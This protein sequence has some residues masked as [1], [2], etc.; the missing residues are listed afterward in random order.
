LG[1]L[2]NRVWDLPAPPDVSVRS[3]SSAVPEIDM[4]WL[5]AAPHVQTSLVRDRA[6]V[7][8]R[9]CDCPYRAYHLTLAERAGQ[10]AGYA[11]HS[12]VQRDNQTSVQIAEIFAP[13]DR[14]ALRALVRDVIDRARA[15][16]ADSVVTHAIPGSSSDR[17]LRRAGFLRGRGG[18]P[19]EVIRLDLEIPRPALQEPH[20]W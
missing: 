3:L 8:W 11:V 20:A 10:P 13:G 7:A 6:W 9:Y 4:V 16:D 15:Q 14:L 2:W 5:R 1:G 17:E 19:L 12:V 18:W